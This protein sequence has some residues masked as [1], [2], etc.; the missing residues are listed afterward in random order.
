MINTPKKAK[1]G[2]RRRPAAGNTGGGVLEISDRKHLTSREYYTNCLVPLMWDSAL[3]RIHL[4]AI[5]SEI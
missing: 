5:L 2:G 3:I 1:T 4:K